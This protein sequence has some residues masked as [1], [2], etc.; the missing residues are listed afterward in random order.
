MP[1]SQMPFW[2]PPAAY[3][4]PLSYPPRFFPD[5]F[6]FLPFIPSLFCQTRGIIAVTSR[7]SPG[8]GVKVMWPMPPTSQDPSSGPSN[9]VTLGRAPWHSQSTLHELESGRFKQRGKEMESTYNADDTCLRKNMGWRKRESTKPWSVW[10][11]AFSRGFTVEVVSPWKKSL[12]NLPWVGRKRKVALS[13]CLNIEIWQVYKVERM[14]KGRRVS[15]LE[16][17]LIRRFFSQGWWKAYS[18]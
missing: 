15:S 16:M 12:R 6:F 11:N 4:C 13:H 14:K 17:S 2:F 10:K 1:V 3:S 8:Q 9:M 18:Y 5:G 7:R